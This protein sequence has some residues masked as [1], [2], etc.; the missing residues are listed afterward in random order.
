[1]L[2]QSTLGGNP[3]NLCRRRKT[4]VLH[5]LQNG[6]KC[7]EIVLRCG[8]SEKLV[9]VITVKNYELKVRKKLPGFDGT[10]KSEKSAISPMCVCAATNPS[11]QQLGI[12]S[13]TEPYLF[14]VRLLH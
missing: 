7:T 13:R 2:G 14:V 6:I 3:G 4:E 12:A 8:C 11:V 5:L 10:A 9:P 1:M